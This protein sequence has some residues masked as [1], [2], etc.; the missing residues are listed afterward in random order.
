MKNL[1]VFFLVYMITALI[2]QVIIK[3]PSLGISQGLTRNRRKAKAPHSKYKEFSC[4]IG[5]HMK[6]QWIL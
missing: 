6:Q 5:I 3:A 2:T 4:V 1:T